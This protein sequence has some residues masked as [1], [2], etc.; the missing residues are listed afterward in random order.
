MIFTTE[1]GTTFEVRNTPFM[2]QEI[3]ES[4]D[5]LAIGPLP[6]DNT[7][8]PFS[9]EQAPHIGKE[10]VIAFPEDPNA[11]SNKW[12]TN[13]WTTDPVVHITF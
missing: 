4:P 1:S 12:T 10:C 6:E 3:R 8:R 9:F 7:F 2:T 5:F 13:R 11:T